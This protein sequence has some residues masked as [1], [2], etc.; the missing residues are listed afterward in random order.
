MLVMGSPHL[1]E[2]LL[3]LK[4]ELQ[5]TVQF[6]TNV[7]AARM[8]SRGVEELLSLTKRISVVEVGFGLGVVGMHLSRVRVAESGPSLFVSNVCR[9]Y[10]R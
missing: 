6:W 4:L 3:G 10:G 2:T 9:T 7:C 5:P 1:E 8:V